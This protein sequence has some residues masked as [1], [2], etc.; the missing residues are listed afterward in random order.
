MSELA[1]PWAFLSVAANLEPEKNIEAAL[2]S[3]SKTV[4]I[5]ELSRFFQT[6]AIGRPEQPDYRNGVAKIACALEP[7]ILK[8]QVLRPI[9][10]EHGRLR[11]VDPF[12]PRTIDLDLLL[13]GNIVLEDEE[14]RLPDPDIVARPFLCAGMLDL[15]PEIVLPGDD[16]P[17]S[18]RADQQA[19][20]ELTE[21]KAL[22]QRLKEQFAQ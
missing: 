14:I 17:L 22:T 1:Q 3:L 19:M 13:F 7:G 2:A 9:E 18:V 11:G 16:Q 4:S 8:K 15:A 20:A 10:E 12:A 21:D 5:V 6:E